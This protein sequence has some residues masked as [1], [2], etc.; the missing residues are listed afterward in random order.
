MCTAALAVSTVCRKPFRIRC[1][2]RFFFLSSRIYL[3]MYFQCHILCFVYETQTAVCMCV[4]V[5]FLPSLRSGCLRSNFYTSVQRTG[6]HSPLCDCLLLIVFIMVV[7]I[8]IIGWCCCRRHS[9]CSF[10]FGALIL[11]LFYIRAYFIFFSVLRSSCVKH[12]SAVYSVKF[13]R[14][15]MS[16]ETNLG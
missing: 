16:T 7:A 5:W 12:S 1:V 15:P 11:I 13:V 2:W 9:R 6:S 14:N 8:I 3:K 10:R 4:C